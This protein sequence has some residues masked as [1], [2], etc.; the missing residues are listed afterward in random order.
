[1]EFVAAAP[2]HDEIL[3]PDEDLVRLSTDPRPPQDL[4]EII[5]LLVMLMPVTAKKYQ[6]SGLKLSAYIFSDSSLY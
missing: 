6:L 2:V 5:I 3:E 1:L 4:R